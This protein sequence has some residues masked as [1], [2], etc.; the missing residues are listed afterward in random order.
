L[1]TPHTSLSDCAKSE[2]IF[3]KEGMLQIFIALRNL[4]PQPGLNLQTLSAIVVVAKVL[5]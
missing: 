2:A 5:L 4:S 3:L 1:F